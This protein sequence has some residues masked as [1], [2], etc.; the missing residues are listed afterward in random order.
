MEGQKFYSTAIGMTES[1]IGRLTMFLGG[2]LFSGLAGGGGSGGGGGGV[3]TGMGNSIGGGR[4]PTSPSSSGASSSNT[5][6]LSSSELISMIK[7]GRTSPIT[8][9]D[10]HHHNKGTGK[11]SNT[12]ANEDGV[13]QG[14]SVAASEALKQEL[15][16]GMLRPSATSPKTLNLPTMSTPPN[17]PLIED[18]FGMLGLAQRLRT[19]QSNPSSLALGMDS[20][21]II[22]NL[23][24]FPFPFTEETCT[25]SEA[26]QP[27]KD[28][29]SNGDSRTGAFRLARMMVSPWIEVGPRKSKNSLDTILPACYNVQAPPHAATRLGSFT[30]ETLFYM[31]YGMPRDRMQ[32]MAAR[33]L[34]LNRGWRYHKD[35]RL[36][37]LPSSATPSPSSMTAGISALRISS[38]PASPSPPSPD[39]AT[40]LA[41]DAQT[42]SYIIFDP[43][44]WSKVRRELSFV[45]DNVL[46]DRFLK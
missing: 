16:S 26:Q 33:E 14:G 12:I 3:G 31:F 37:L 8:R 22:A 18:D 43:N 7:K 44:T 21:S 38:P 34:T 35:L 36:W 1:G 24:A 23:T 45:K 42:A 40:A 6:G 39:A 4:S 2:S 15:L 10:S 28:I 25:T 13:I 11:T 19:A 9:S 46:E 32:E 17:S 5:A 30:E 27:E 29:S 41:D 20:E